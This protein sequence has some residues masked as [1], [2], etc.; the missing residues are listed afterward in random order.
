MTLM[1]QNR[2]FNNSKIK[3]LIKQIMT[4]PKDLRDYVLEKYIESCKEIHSL[5]YM[6]WR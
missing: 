6:E 2:T 5:A 1:S 4:I 3:E